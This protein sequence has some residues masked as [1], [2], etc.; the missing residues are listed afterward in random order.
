MPIRCGFCERHPIFKGYVQGGDA[1]SS[2][3]VAA[4]LIQDALRRPLPMIDSS[5]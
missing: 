5:S 2:D 3:C 1:Q 4:S